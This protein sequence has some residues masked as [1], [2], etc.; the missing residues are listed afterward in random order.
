VSTPT[1]PPSPSAIPLRLVAV[2]AALVVV[3]AVVLALVAFSG[4]DDDNADDLSPRAIPSATTS[5]TST[6]PTEAPNPAAPVDATFPG[7]V[8]DLGLTRNHAGRGERITYPDA[9]EHPPLG[10]NH[11]AIWMDCRAYPAPVPSENAVHSLEHGAVWITYRPDLAASDVSALAA[12]AG[13]KDKVLVS[14]YAQD[15][16]VVLTAWGRQLRLAT[17]D[18]A[19]AQRFVD[20]YADGPQTPEPGASCESPA[21]QPGTAPWV[22]DPLTQSVTPSTSTES[23]PA[24]GKIG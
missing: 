14:P 21:D 23:V 24:S 9:A 15:D 1:T 18:A 6:P 5:A 4:G 8:V 19:L 2:V 16:A 3:I 13:N 22:Y 7:L 17:P 20:A 12:L 10:G 11:A